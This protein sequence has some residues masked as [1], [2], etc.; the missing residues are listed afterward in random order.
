MKCQP[1]NGTTRVV[2]KRY[3]TQIV[4]AEGFKGV[5]N[6]LRY[7]VPDTFS[8][9]SITALQLTR[10][11]IWRFGVSLFATIYWRSIPLA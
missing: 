10:L 8:H 2:Q 11:A 5:R 4:G 3:E 9:P 6:R 7:S 1:P